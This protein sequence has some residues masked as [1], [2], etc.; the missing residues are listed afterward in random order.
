M[1]DVQSHSQ[2]LSVRLEQE[3]AKVQKAEAQ[4]E[5]SSRM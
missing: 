2:G 3:S 1:H 5:S 4:R